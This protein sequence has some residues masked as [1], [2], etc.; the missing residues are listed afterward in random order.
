MW[1]SLICYKYGDKTKLKNS[2]LNT[3]I[4]SLL[5]HLE[6]FHCNIPLRRGIASAAFSIQFLWSWRSNS[7]IVFQLDS[8]GCESPT[9]PRAALSSRHETTATLQSLGSSL[10]G[11]FSYI[12]L[13]S[14][15]SDGAP[16]TP[17]PTLGKS[18]IKKKT[19]SNKKKSEATASRF[20]S[21]GEPTPEEAQERTSSSELLSETKFTAPHGSYPI[22]LDSGDKTGVRDLVVPIGITISNL[23][24]LSL[25]FGQ[26]NCT[27]WIIIKSS[28]R[29]P[30]LRSK[31]LFKGQKN[32][33][34]DYFSKIFK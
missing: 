9:C 34:C 1:L 13:S 14:Q 33:R 21:C 18:Y 6:H 16:G 12:Q 19:G 24:I 5:W 10:G 23:E 27:E 28:K 2:S 7:P 31:K 20:T 29:L 11:E 3:N 4:R 15:S 26:L 8:S 30:I 17:K 22:K 32:H 25:V